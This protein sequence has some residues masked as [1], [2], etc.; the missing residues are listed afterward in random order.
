MLFCA[1]FALISYADLEV[2]AAKVANEKDW[3]K[4]KRAN[5]VPSSGDIISSAFGA[6]WPVKL[7][8][9]DATEPSPAGLVPSSDAS[10]QE[11]TVSHLIQQGLTVGT[12]FG[13]V[14]CPVYMKTSD[15]RRF[16][17]WTTLSNLT[18][19]IS[20][21][22]GRL[23]VV[24]DCIVKQPI[25]CFLYYMGLPISSKNAGGMCLL[26]PWRPRPI[27]TEIPCMYRPI[28]SICTVW[29]D[30]ELP[31]HCHEIRNSSDIDCTH[32]VVLLKEE[33]SGPGHTV[34]CFPD[35]RLTWIAFCIHTILIWESGMS[36]FDNAA[37]VRWRLRVFTCWIC[38]P[39]D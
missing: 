39:K 32:L 36:V 31:E 3:A 35:N 27:Y 34:F 18:D 19:K 24:L 14:Q 7:G 25:S 17:T 4:I 30:F 12:Q 23:K 2:L 26:I 15:V 9:I 33:L 29:L 1:G 10:V 16:N 6:A 22:L 37:R 21:N 8:R 13:R 28:H 5:G 38:L 20:N 11:I